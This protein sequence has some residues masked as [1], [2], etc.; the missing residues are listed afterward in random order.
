MMTK[1][2]G[3]LTR[4]L[5][6]EV[7]MEVG[8]YE[9]AVMVPESVRR[10]LQLRTGDEMTL[11]L[12]EYYEGNQS[13]S[14]LVPRKVGFLSEMDLEF[15][16]LFC[17]VDKIG[18]KK[19]LK[20]LSRP[21]REIAD[22]ISRQ[23]TKWLTTLPGI[24]AATAELIISTLKRKVTRF[25]LSPTMATATEPGA[26]PLPETGM[27]GQLIEDLYQTLMAL[28]HNPLEARAKL[29]T[30]LQSKQIFTT[31]EDAIPLIYGK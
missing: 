16:E 6:D 31:V 12:S 19:A 25:A 18:V 5:D 20:A 7:R 14:R 28:G 10:Q 13:G 23:D 27:S 30:L 11:H 4:V 15:F 8:P 24:G 21:A 9:F 2:R 22:A 17:T 29:D 3:I 26:T 1:L